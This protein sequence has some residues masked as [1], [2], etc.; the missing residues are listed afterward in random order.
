MVGAGAE[1]PAVEASTAT[2]I[3]AI[4]SWLRSSIAKQYKSSFCDPIK[5]HKWYTKL[6]QHASIGKVI[7]MSSVGW[8]W[9]KHCNTLGALLWVGS[10]VPCTT[11][12]SVTQ[13]NRAPYK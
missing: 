8:V 4:K 7:V 1:S 11:P 13:N 5:L 3:F 12:I 10:D 9:K 6:Q 2:T